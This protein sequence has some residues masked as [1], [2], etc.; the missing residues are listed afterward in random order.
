M[1]VKSARVV[2]GQEPE[3]TNSFLIDLAEC[4]SDPMYD[5]EEAVRRCLGGEQPGDRPPPLRKVSS[6][7]L[8]PL[9]LLNGLQSSSSSAAESKSDHSPAPAET[10]HS[11]GAESKDSGA[12][13]M[14][15]VDMAQ[16][17]PER[18]KS[19]GGTR[20]GKPAQATADTGLSG[21]FSG[22]AAPQLD[23]EIEKCDGSDAVTQQLLGD[24]ISKPKLSE[25]LLAK[26]PFRFL[27][28]IVME[29][30]R[31][32]GFGTGL[33]APAEMD[34]AA[35]SDK[36]QKLLFLDKII[37]LVGVQLNTLVEAKP[38]KIVAGLDPQSTNN[39]L[40]L[41]AV[42]ARHMP[43]STKAVRTVL[44]Q[45]GE[46]GG[47]EQPPQRPAQQESKPVPVEERRPEERRPAPRQVGLP[48]SHQCVSK[49]D[50]SAE[51]KEPVRVQEEPQREIFSEDRPVVVSGLSVAS[52]LLTPAL[53]DD[54]EMGDGEKKRSSRPTSALRRPPKVKVNAK[55]L[56]A[57]DTAPA[58]RKAE[59]III[60][61]HNDDV[62]RLAVLLLLL[63]VAS[64]LTL[65]RTRTRSRRT[66]PRAWW[67]R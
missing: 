43:D 27:H 7:L 49:S 19:R 25:K 40:Q 32:T 1:P 55:E 53:Q 13:A 48:F 63:F 28:D 59:G 18:G 15:D 29:V 45:L 4:A 46:A 33:Y 66:P 17:A 41:L 21:G 56:Q 5:S 20:G 38:M 6:E 35:I 9:W 36:A 54:S 52:L 26:P 34:S 11:S 61:G 3:H 37:R 16:M 64:M 65:R 22:P 31:V 60:D 14:Q 50:Q 23:S 8:T 57:K 12:K 47:E 24:L 51:P 39:L 42:A 2:S 62:S 10:K 67:T 30:L 58:A 44:E